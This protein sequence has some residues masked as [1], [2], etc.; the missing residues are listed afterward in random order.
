M[1]PSYNKLVSHMFEPAVRTLEAGFSASQ[2]A[3]IVGHGPIE[4][5]RRNI[6]SALQPGDVFVWVGAANME[7][8]ESK[9][10]APFVNMV[11]FNLTRLG[12][13]TVYYSTEANE[14]HP[15]D[16]KRRLPVREIW[17]YTRKNAICCPDEPTRVRV[18][19][20][21]PGFS[22]RRV[23]AASHLQPTAPL[24][25]AFFG[26]ASSV[27]DERKACL[28]H[29]TRGL[30]VGLPNS[31][32]ASCVA[33]ACLRKCGK[34]HCPLKTLHRIDT[35]VAW[36]NSLAAHSVFLNVHK[37]CE[38]GAER[39]DSYLPSTASCESFRLADLLSSGAEIVSE[40]CH[41][42]DEREYYG[43][44]T[45]L[46]IPKVS[47]AVL[48][49]WAE[50]DKAHERAHMRM[51]EFKTRFAP[52]RIFERAGITTLLATLRERRSR[53]H[54]SRVVTLQ[55]PVA[56]PESRPEGESVP[57]FCCFNR[58]E[59][60]LKQLE[61]R[62]GKQLRRANG[63]RSWGDLV[64]KLKASQVSRRRHARSQAKWAMRPAG[65]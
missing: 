22:G 10:V 47:T 51:T 37:A 2:L 31:L 11:L 49:A 7:W 58:D 12:V 27:Y 1:E 21:P 60:E 62:K 64:N 42:A 46:P 8:A 41:P 44:V 5:I 15:C 53:D 59:C 4:L 32:P 29:I 39:R 35:E 26:S 36:N 16:E 23:V 6:V 61:S 63:T 33:T 50:R 38:W 20:V 54:W 13:L 3:T 18:R 14:H 55:A 34:H 28:E 57:N 48:A 17:E 43:L 56:Y 25:L 19:Y 52:V 40:H 45:F 65:S 9:H 24:T 30:V